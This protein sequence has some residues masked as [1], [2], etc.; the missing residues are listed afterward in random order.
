MVIVIAI[1]IMK[2][3]NDLDKTSIKEIFWK[4]SI[5]SSFKMLENI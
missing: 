1:K 3:L 5:K 2:T 4:F